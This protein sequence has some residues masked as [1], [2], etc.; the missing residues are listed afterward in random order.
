[1]SNLAATKP[2]Y[3]NFFWCADYH[4]IRIPYKQSI[5][6]ANRKI[7]SIDIMYIFLADISNEINIIYLIAISNEITGGYELSSNFKRE[8]N[9]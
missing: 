8:G 6:I 5:I 3:M 2:H 7:I 4:N 9:S 1:M